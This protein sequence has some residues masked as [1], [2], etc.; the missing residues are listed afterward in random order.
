MKPEWEC[1]LPRPTQ[2]DLR[3]TKQMDF[4]PPNTRA[5]VLPKRPCRAKML[6]NWS[7]VPPTNAISPTGNPAKRS[8]SSPKNS[9]TAATSSLSSPN[10]LTRTNFS[11]QRPAEHFSL[12]K[13]QKRPD[14]IAVL[15]DFYGSSSSKLQYKAPGKDIEPGN[16]PL[17]GNQRNLIGLFPPI[18]T[19]TTTYQAQFPIKE[20]TIQPPVKRM[21]HRSLSHDF[22]PSSH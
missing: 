16:R 8:A 11:P 7:V 20:Q 1:S 15:S 2:M 19:L 14:P 21:A 6:S 22:L 12:R 18:R 5:I 13:G 4:R 17:R 9:P 3:T 10:P